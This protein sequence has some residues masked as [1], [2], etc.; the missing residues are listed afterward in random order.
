MIHLIMKTEIVV[1]ESSFEA[2]HLPVMDSERTQR[3][4]TTIEIDGAIEEV[5]GMHQSPSAARCQTIPI[6]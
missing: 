6:Q 3:M 4:Y 1:L 2:V 5:G